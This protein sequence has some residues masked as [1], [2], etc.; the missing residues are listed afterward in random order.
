MKVAQVA[1]L[2][3][4]RLAV[5]GCGNRAPTADCQSAT[6]QSATLRYDSESLWR[7]VLLRRNP[8]RDDAAGNFFVQRDAD[9]D[10]F[11]LGVNVL[12]NR[13]LFQLKAPA[14]W[15]KI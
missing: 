8:Q 2:L 15:V 9:A 7:E 11:A 6:Q 13:F 14:L 5:G 4:R 10:G 3:L 12:V 1:N